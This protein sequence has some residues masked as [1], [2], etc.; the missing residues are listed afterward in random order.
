MP[1]TNYLPSSR[2]IQ[3]G[4]CTSSTRPASPYEGMVIYETDTN[5]VRVYDGSAWVMIADTDTPP[6]LELIKA[7]TVGSAVSS[8]TVNS[9]FSSTYDAYRLVVSAVNCS[10]SDTAMYLQMTT[11]GTASTASYN[12]G[13]PR[14]DIANG[15]VSST[16]SQS[17]T[18]MWVSITSAST[19]ASMD[20]LDSYASAYTKF[21]HISRYELSTGYFG[22]G[23]GQHQVTTSYD[24]IK[25][26][27]SS[28]TMTGGTIRVY[29]YRNTI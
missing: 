29:G 14:V 16:Y 15:N 5:Q 12:Y 13:I 28:G 20:I 27:P 8:V 19:S 21:P 2:L 22:A 25:I 23:A 26:Y 9:V 18:Q 6:G 1:L 11:G 10:T 24:G 17:G 3:P 7:Q 4:V